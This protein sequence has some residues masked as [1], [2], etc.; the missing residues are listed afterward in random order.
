MATGVSGYVDFVNGTYGIT[1]RVHYSQTYNSGTNK[2]VVAITNVEVKSTSY[3]G[4][5]YLDGTFSIDGIAAVSMS[6]NNGSHYANINS[7]DTFYTVNGDMG[8]VTV[9]HDENYSKTVTIVQSDIKGYYNGSVKWT[10][11]TNT[12]TIELTKIGGFIYIDNGTSFDK[13]EVYID[14]GT[15]WDRYMPY[16]DNGSGWDMCG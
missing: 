15:S 5:Y 2:S 16:I 13:Y 7:V 6:I 12:D 9:D 14:N 3:V 10:A 8:S 11:Y 4:Q 1:F